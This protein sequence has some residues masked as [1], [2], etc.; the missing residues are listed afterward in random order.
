MASSS[1]HNPLLHARSPVERLLRPRSVAVIGDDTSQ[2]A[3]A[4]RILGHLLAGGFSG[5]VMPVFPGHDAV[6]GV[7]AYPSAAALP[8]APDLA[9]VSLPPDAAADALAALAARGAGGAV[10]TGEAP[11][12]LG[13]GG[14]GGLRVIGA[15]SGGLIIPALGLNASFCQEMPK[16][17]GIA[18]LCHDLGIASAVLAHAAAEGLGISHVISLGRNDDLGFTAMLDWLA[19]DGTTRVVLLE[20][21]RIKDRR[22]F[23][24]AARA[25]A[26]TRPVVAL[27]T[28]P[29]ETG[30]GED[31]QAGSGLVFAAAVRRVGVVD[32]EGLEDLL[33]AA[34]ILS[35][36]RRMRG[37]RVLVVSDAP[38]LGRLAAREAASRGATIA[39]PEAEE[40]AALGLLLGGGAGNPAIV[41]A[42]QPA[43][44]LGEAVA[45][46][47]GL[48]GLADA[49]LAVH[50]SVEG[51][52]AEATVAAEAL[53]AA[54]ATLRDRPLIVAWPGG[55]AAS[56]A[57]ARLGSAGVAVFP[58][59]EAAA[60]AASALIR[61]RRTR[62]A[63][64]ELPP[65]T[66]LSIAPDRE[67]VRRLLED[68]RAAGRSSLTEDEAAAVLAAY[69]ITSA[70]AEVA[71]GPDEA[72]A[73]AARLGPPVVLKIRSPDLVHKTDVGGVVLDLDT[74]DAV[75]AA[76]EAMAARIARLAPAIRTEGFLV[77]RQIRRAG[78]RELVIRLGRDALFGPTISFGQGGTAVGVAA[79]IAA[80]LP[81]LNRALAASL[82][83]RTRVARLLAGFR[84]HR[85]IDREA[86]HEALVRLS[87]LSVDFPDILA[88]DVNPLVAGPDG[89]IALD[90]WIAIAPEPLAGTG[91]LAIAPYP[92]ERVTAVTLRDGRKVTLRP[93]RPED[94]EAHAAFFAR[95]T[96]ED[97][98]F[99]F[100][101]PIRA[102]SPEQL[103]RMTQIDY[104]REMAI[105]ATDEAGADGPET[106]GVIRIIRTGETGE[107]AIVVRSDAKGTGLGKQ[108]TEA[109]LAWARDVGIRRVV[110]EV[111]AENAPMLGFVRSLGFTLTR[112][113]DDPELMI[114]AIDLD[115][116]PL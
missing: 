109:G 97:V 78:A 29:D 68:V 13:A 9:I 20:V 1:P 104:D 72:A 30:V 22:G 37:E 16:A 108:L 5:A 82:V 44:R 89:V 65:S 38:S 31:G 91:H 2:D 47:G 75:R 50:A 60:R 98:R 88:A 79:D 99:R 67:R 83:A 66:V 41:P 110:G 21:G 3:P 92:A 25:V 23:L 40:S 69:G 52:E 24:S 4:R 63:A 46:A 116:D 115:R 57:R 105:I 7:L 49:V 56:A 6:G 8:R 100:F 18:L 80:D 95:L 12:G 59:I 84:D 54:A 64:R 74:P 90:A 81:P 112:S 35:R 28:A 10:L 71:A 73:A 61:D 17:G 101:A 42:S 86:I 85:A 36:P 87:Q 51:S 107:F 94:A 77:Q 11:P 103:A 48:A 62:E 19:R 26:R 32:A 55:V 39:Q 70:P 33:D 15:L 58:T 114:A 45:A 102:L 43:T 27:R 76:A 106:L 53:V 113:E 93:I 96:P 111:L 14:L 34:T